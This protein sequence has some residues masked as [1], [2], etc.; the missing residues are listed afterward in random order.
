M[1]PMTMEEQTYTAVE[2]R[3]NPETEIAALECIG[4]L[5]KET[6]G[7]STLLQDKRG[8]IFCQTK[9]TLV[10]KINGIL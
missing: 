4:I 3:Q 10:F 2:Q 5:E 1:A 7:F 8:F 9:D 6:F